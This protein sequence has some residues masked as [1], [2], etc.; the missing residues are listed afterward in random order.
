MEEK[1]VREYLLD[2]AHAAGDSKARF[3]FGR[4]FRPEAWGK[5]AQALCRHPEW[6]PA[7][8]GSEPCIRTVWE[9]ASPGAPPRLL[10]AHPKS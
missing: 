10:T 8:D 6:S 9:V 4:G 1:K 5:L 2:L 3:F 7:A